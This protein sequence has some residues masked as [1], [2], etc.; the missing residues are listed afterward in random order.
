MDLEESPMHICFAY[1][2]T[3]NLHLHYK[4]LTSF[5]FWQELLKYVTNI[6]YF[7]DCL[8]NYHFFIRYNWEHNLQAIFSDTL[9][10]IKCV[11]D[12]LCSKYLLLLLVVNICANELSMNLDN[13]I[14]GME[15]LKW[16]LLKHICLTSAAA[17]KSG[18]WQKI[19]QIPEKM[20]IS[21]KKYERGFQFYEEMKRRH[22]ILMDD[23]LCISSKKIA[24]TCFQKQRWSGRSFFKHIGYFENTQET[25]KL[26]F[27]FGFSIWQWGSWKLSWTGWNFTSLWAL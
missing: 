22:F 5:K 9:L 19:K 27:Y 14:E 24:V 7:S 16:R 6:N 1:G 15:I 26:S 20:I 21:K 18:I 10:W 4:K 25:Y 13:P 12:T 17:F 3:G 8:F 11:F 2:Y 23:R